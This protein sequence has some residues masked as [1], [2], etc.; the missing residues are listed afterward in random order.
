[1]TELEID[2]NQKI[3]EWDVIQEAGK[4]LKVFESGASMLCGYTMCYL[5]VCCHTPNLLAS[6][7]LWA[8]LHWNAQLRKQLLHELCN[9]N[10]IHDPRFPEEVRTLSYCYS[11]H[12]VKLNIQYW[13]AD[14]A[15]QR[16]RFSTCVQEAIRARTSDC[17]CRS[18]RTVCWVASTRKNRKLPCPTPTTNPLSLYVGISLIV[19]SLFP[20]VGWQLS[21][22]ERHQTECVQNADRQRPSRVLH[23]TTAGCA[24]VPPALVRRHRGM[25]WDI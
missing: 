23:Q 14:T 7:D 11:L 5:H 18:S 9:A 17:R 21:E 8:G 4:E 2:L 10:T 19:S 6:A 25:E 1:M 15:H 24:R 3:G 12:W 13:L 22:E 16:K 20:H